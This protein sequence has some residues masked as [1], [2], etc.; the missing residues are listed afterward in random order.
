MKFEPKKVFVLENN[1]YV[2]IT[3][4]E[5]LQRQAS[6]PAYNDKWF[7]VLHG[8]LMEVTEEHYREHYKTKRRQKYLQECAAENGE[9]SLE[10]LDTEE[11][12]GT[13][14]LVDYDADVAKQVEHKMLL[15]KLHD[16][17]PLLSDAERKLIQ[18]HFFEGIPET[19]LADTYGVTQQ[20]ISKRIKKICG[21]LKEFLEN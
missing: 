21:K 14:I 6:E 8:Y 16:V 17:L 13:D 4:E 19:K 20:A 10:M 3:H 1:E 7:I 9:I 18:E 15:D 2:E 11:F 5:H 12:N